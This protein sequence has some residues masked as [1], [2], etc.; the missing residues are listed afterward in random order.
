MRKLLPLCVLLLLLAGC[1]TVNVNISPARDGRD[2]T[3]N[4]TVSGSDVETDVK[5]K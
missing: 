3:V 5:A 4:V 2:V 1:K